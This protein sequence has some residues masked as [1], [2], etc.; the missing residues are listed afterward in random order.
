MNHAEWC[1]NQVGCIAPSAKP[2]SICKKAFNTTASK[3]DKLL[4]QLR[5]IKA[6]KK[7]GVGAAM[8]WN[9]GYK[10]AISEAISLAE[11]IQEE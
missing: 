2:C 6:E 11:K 8:H 9:E 7:Y 3:M 10:E 5:E 4:K 1:N